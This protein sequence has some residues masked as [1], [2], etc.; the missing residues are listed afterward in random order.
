FA[1]KAAMTEKTCIIILDGDN[2]DEWSFATEVP[3]K[4]KLLFA[5]LAKPCPEGDAKA[6]AKWDDIN[7]QAM[8]KICKR[9]KP[10]Y[11]E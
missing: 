2:Y 6:T 11:Y 5:A 9:I 4:S 1:V 7:T 3:L 10:K 8:G